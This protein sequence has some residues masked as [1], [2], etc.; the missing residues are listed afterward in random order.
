MKIFLLSAILV[1]GCLSASTQE[2]AYFLNWTTQQS[3]SVKKE[4]NGTI[5]KIELPYK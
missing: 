1:L 3:D 2:E 4:G 5:F